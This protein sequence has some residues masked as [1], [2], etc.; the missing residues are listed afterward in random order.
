MKINN[1]YSIWCYVLLVH[2][3]YMCCVSQGSSYELIN[4]DMLVFAFLSH[5]GVSVLVEML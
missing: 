5:E 3:Y 1:P 4:G 2:E